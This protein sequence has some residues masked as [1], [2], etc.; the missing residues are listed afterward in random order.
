MTVDNQAPRVAW[1]PER[2][3]MLADLWSKGFSAA[4]I[5]DM[6]GGVTKNSV[7]GKRHRLGLYERSPTSARKSPIYKRPRTDRPPKPKAERKTGL[8]KHKLKPADVEFAAKVQDVARVTFDEL[9]PHHCHWPV[10]EPK[11][12]GFGYCGE[13]R[14]DG[15]PYC[16]AHAIRASR[17]IESFETEPT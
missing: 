14:A 1:T 7:I 5:A 10:G 9:E 13:A 3:K 17:Q 16:R 2:E 11:K 6:L 8:Q 4:R 15:L 12:P